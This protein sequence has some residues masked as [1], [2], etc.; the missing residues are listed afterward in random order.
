[1]KTSMKRIRNSLF[2]WI[3]ALALTAPAFAD[4]IAPPEPLP[5]VPQPEEPMLAPLLAGAVALAAAAVLAWRLI[6]R[7][8]ER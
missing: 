8:K 3:T 2:A 5:P 1:M 6:R 4:I 7:R